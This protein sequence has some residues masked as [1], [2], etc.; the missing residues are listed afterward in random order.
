MTAFMKAAKKGRPVSRKPGRPPKSADA[1]ERQMVGT[2]LSPT[3]YERLVEAAAANGRSIS[4]EVEWRIEKSLVPDQMI[5]NSTELNE[6][7]RHVIDAF[8]AG[9]RMNDPA[10]PVR[11]WIKDPLQYN[12]ALVRAFEALLD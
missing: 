9:G 10:R 12:R 8:E 3:T 1:V 6:L 11:E 7:A 2:R 5:P 4:S